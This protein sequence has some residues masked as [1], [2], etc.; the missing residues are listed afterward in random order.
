MIGKHENA[1]PIFF[2]NKIIVLKYNRLSE[3]LPY[4]KNNV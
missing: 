3:P 1:L 4:N 2:L